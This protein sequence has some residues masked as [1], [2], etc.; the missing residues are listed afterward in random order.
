[1]GQFPAHGRFHHGAILPPEIQLP[2]KTQWIDEA[3][4][5]INPRHL[6]IKGRKHAMF[7]NPL[8]GQFSVGLQERQQ[9]RT[10]D[11]D[12]GMRLVETGVSNLETGVILETCV[13]QLVQLRA[14]ELLP[15]TIVRPFRDW[16]L[17][18]V[19]NCMGQCLFHGIRF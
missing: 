2:S 17:R 5:N 13:N 18:F 16:L 11:A 14:A 6:R 8:C 15:P 19:M 4:R 7:G 3:Q 12:Q 10:F 1:M 9:P